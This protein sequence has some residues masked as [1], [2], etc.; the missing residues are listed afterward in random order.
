MSSN[1][2]TPRKQAVSNAKTGRRH[3]SDAE[4]LKIV[5]ESFEKG[6]VQA[7]LARR[8]GISTSQLWDWRARYKAG[9][10]EDR[11][12]F[13]QVVVTQETPE[14]VQDQARSAA[15]CPDLVIEVGQ[16]YRFT[17]P[18]GFDMDA[19]ARLLRGLA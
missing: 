4:K 9:L 13:S 19:A 6:C 10:L 2:P 11:A 18:A 15:A 17:I 7:Q 3:R 8:H 14:G 12:D 1:K 16:C 5:K